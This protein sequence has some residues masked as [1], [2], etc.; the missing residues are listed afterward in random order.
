MAKRVELDDDFEL[1]SDN[2][3]LSS[4]YG[5]YAKASNGVEKPNI[6][7]KASKIETVKLL[8]R[9]EGEQEWTERGIVEVSKDASGKV[10]GVIVHNDQISAQANT[11]KQEF[12]RQCKQG[13]FYQLRVP[14]YDLQTSI[15]ACFYSQNGFNDTLIFH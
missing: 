1:D 11:L 15:P 4:S 12:E 7:V 5:S 10:I 9:F 13:K 8:K 3:R 14:E 2:E 6:P